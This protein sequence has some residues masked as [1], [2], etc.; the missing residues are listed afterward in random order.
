MRGGV[1][2]AL[3]VLPAE[4]AT[5]AVASPRS[6]M[7]PILLAAPRILNEPVFCRFSHFSQTS[8]PVRA[9]KVE[10]KSRSVSWIMPEMRFA[11]RSKSLRVSAITVT[12]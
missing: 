8:P 5:T 4:E 12:S 9:E 6:T 11:A 3:G 7:A 2:H 1:G 10:L